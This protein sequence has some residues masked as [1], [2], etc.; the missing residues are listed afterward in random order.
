ML[1]QILSEPFYSDRREW[2]PEGAPPYYKSPCFHYH[3]N[4]LAVQEVQPNIEVRPCMQLFLN[5]LGGLRY[6]VQRFQRCGLTF[7]VVQEVQ[8]ATE[9]FM[10]RHCEAPHDSHVLLSFCLDRP[11][12]VQP[13]NLMFCFFLKHKPESVFCCIK[14]KVTSDRKG[15]AHCH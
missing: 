4:T 3:D 7:L 9:G 6:K 5:A 2:W 10:Y 8:A 13:M 15:A 11:L 14:R 1:V 12:A